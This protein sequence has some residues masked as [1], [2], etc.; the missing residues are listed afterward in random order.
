LRF[1]VE[2]ASHGLSAIAELLVYIPYLNLTPINSCIRNYMY[3]CIYT[4]FQKKLDHQT[5][6]GNFVKS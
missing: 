4:V 1:D 5:D 2:Q 6:G 3:I